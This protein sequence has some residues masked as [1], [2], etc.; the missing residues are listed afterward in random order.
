MNAN[1]FRN[2]LSRR[3]FLRLAAAGAGTASASGWLPVLAAHAA[4]KGVKHKSC[5]LLYMLGG[6]VHERWSFTAGKQRETLTVSGDR[7]SDDADVVRRWAVAGRGL[8]YKSWLDVADDV[9]AGRLEVALEG[10]LG[11]PTPLNL[12]CAHRDRLSGP[13]RLLREFLQQRCAELLA[14]APWSL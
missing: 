5:I 1:A 11:E 6:R 7:V 10:W 3:D 8:V 14:G 2:R 9:Q 12:I 13:V 4:D